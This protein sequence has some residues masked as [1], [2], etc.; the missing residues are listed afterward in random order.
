MKRTDDEIND[1]LNELNQKRYWKCFIAF[2]IFIFLS[3]GIGWGLFNSM[4]AVNDITLKIVL[5]VISNIVTGGLAV[6][7]TKELPYSLEDTTLK[8]GRWFLERD[9]AQKLE[10]LGYE[11][12]IESFKNPLR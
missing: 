9:I 6:F 10:I 11:K 8:R 12:S 2:I 3:G 4:Q 5:F 1:K 7:V